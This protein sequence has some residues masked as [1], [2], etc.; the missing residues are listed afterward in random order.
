M[1]IPFFFFFLSHHLEFFYGAEYLL[2]K[3]EDST[4]SRQGHK[5]S[6]GMIEEGMGRTSMQTSQ[7]FFFNSYCRWFWECSH[8]RFLV[9][10]VLFVKLRPRTFQLVLN[11][12][13]STSIN[14]IPL[15][16]A[17]IVV[18]ETTTGTK[19]C[20]PLVL[21]KAEKP[22]CIGSTLAL[23]GGKPCRQ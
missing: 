4:Q 17:S 6:E 2:T 1:Q 16:A 15:P 7:H 18:A 13:Q 20:K 22:R 14:S 11:S 3:Y 9:N 10:T 8:E 12:I 23:I 19:K 21:G 5:M